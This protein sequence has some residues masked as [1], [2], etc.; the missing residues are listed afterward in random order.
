MGSRSASRARPERQ[1]QSDVPELYGDPTLTDMEEAEHIER[2]VVVAIGAR[3]ER[4]RVRVGLPRIGA[5]EVR[6]HH[7]VHH[8]AIGGGASTAH[9]LH[10]NEDWSGM[11]PFES[12][13]LAK[14][15]RRFLY[16]GL[17]SRRRET[18]GN[19]P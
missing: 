3:G 12:A 11:T 10:L 4:K 5:E 15:S 7:D 6:V 1:R 9:R 17:F 14:N 2:A 8:T 18:L 13:A 16:F 19:K